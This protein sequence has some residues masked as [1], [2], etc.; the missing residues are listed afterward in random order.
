MLWDLFKFADF[1]CH[2]IKLVIEVDG[3]SH[4]LEQQI[5][6]DKI[7]DEEDETIRAHNCPFYEREY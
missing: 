4:E 2:R 7:R 6:H 5:L 3:R 1:Y